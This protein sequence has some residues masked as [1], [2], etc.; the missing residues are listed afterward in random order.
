M[1]AR[2][3]KYTSAYRE[4]ALK[5]LIRTAVVQNVSGGKKR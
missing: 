4:D 3:N 2:L 1:N 5:D